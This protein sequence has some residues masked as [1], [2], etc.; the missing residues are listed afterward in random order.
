MQ[1]IFNEKPKNGVR[2][3]IVAGLV[4]CHKLKLRMI[5][6]CNI[7]EELSKKHDNLQAMLEES[8]N[9]LMEE[10]NKRLAVLSS[11]R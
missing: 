4:D 6:A 3:K 11:L 10:I 1:R 5:E 2:L 7:A 9:E 8:D